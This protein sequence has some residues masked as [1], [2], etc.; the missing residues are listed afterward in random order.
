V[1]K[2][3]I[4]NPK[5]P[6]ADRLIRFTLR[7]RNDTLWTPARKAM[8][9]KDSGID[10]KC[11]CG[12]R[13]F[14]DLLHI[15]NNCGYNLKEMTVRH[16]M[17]QE[18]LVEAIRKH[19]KVSIEEILTKEG[20]NH[21]KFQKELGKPKLDENEEKQRPD[22][23]FWADV[24]NEDDNYETRKLFIIEISEPFGKIDQDDEHSNTLKNEI[25]FKTNKYAPLVRSIN[26]Q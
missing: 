18:V 4:S 3:F 20:I 6:N 22:I 7:A 1:P 25:E 21:G 24:S 12:N 17:I 14:C 19:R 8:I 10:T 5:A 26:K 2:F 9:F 15:L 16:N 13:K 23:Q 11:T